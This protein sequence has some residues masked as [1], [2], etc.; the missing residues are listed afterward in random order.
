MKHK[1]YLYYIVI[2][3]IISFS[4]N[5]LY[6]LGT[7]FYTTGRAGIG[8][9]KKG[10]PVNYCIGA[11]FIL[12]TAVARDELFNYRVN[13]GWGNQ[14]ESGSP[15]FSKKSVQRVSVSNN[16]GLGVLRKKYIRLWV[17]PQ[18]DIG[19]Q[20]K[21][22]TERYLDFAPGP[23]MGYE[24]HSINMAMFYL[25]FGAVFGININ[26][27]D[28]FTLG[29]EIGVNTALVF[30]K[31]RDTTQSV[32]FIQDFF[33]GIKIIPMITSSNDDDKAFGRIEGFSRISFI[34]RV[35]DTYSETAL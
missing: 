17:G 16:F 31:H 33:S 12:D 22:N 24:L 19:C 25:G 32:L 14:A 1:K 2:L 9:D 4:S 26:T 8:Y 34:F 5:S 35:G 28:L 15:F 10:F 27:G 20:F 29:F 23:S 21:Q 3:S 11:G 7:G 18:L 30:G 6:A 13:V